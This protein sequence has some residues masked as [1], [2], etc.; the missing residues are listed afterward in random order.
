MVISDGAVRATSNDVVIEYV[1]YRYVI[2]P[3]NLKIFSMV[4][5]DFKKIDGKIKDNFHKTI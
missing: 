2:Y 4:F 5:T 1:I 3:C